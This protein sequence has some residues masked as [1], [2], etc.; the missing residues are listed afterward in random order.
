MIRGVQNAEFLLFSW[1]KAGTKP[2]TIQTHFA[3]TAT[4]INGIE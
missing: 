2:P 3:T 1:G 4:L